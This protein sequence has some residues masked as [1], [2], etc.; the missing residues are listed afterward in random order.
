MRAE[1][2]KQVEKKYKG[3]YNKWTGVLQHIIVWSRADLSHTIMRL[4]GYNAAPLLPYWKA[5]DHTMI[6]LYHKPHIPCQDGGS[7]TGPQ[8]QDNPIKVW[9]IN[10]SDKLYHT[11]CT[12]RIF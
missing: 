1:E 4:S 6:Y 11:K 12:E 8:F 10:R 9:D 7:I 2:L 5:L 3:K